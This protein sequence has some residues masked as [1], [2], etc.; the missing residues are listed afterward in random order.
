MQIYHWG[1]G[2]LG[3]EIV[4]QQPVSL[5]FRFSTVRIRY[6]FAP[7]NI[8]FATSVNP[9]CYFILNYNN[10]TA[11]TSIRYLPKNLRIELN[12][13]FALWKAILATD[14]QLSFSLSPVR[15]DTIV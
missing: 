1:E 14:L 4:F 15:L 11:K 2:T 8:V 13:T 6:L 10:D 7:P 12:W 5:H 9:V 3:K